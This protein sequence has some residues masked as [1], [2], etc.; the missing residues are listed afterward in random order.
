MPAVSAVLITLDEEARI[1]RALRSVAFCDEVL[2]VDAG[3]SDRTCELAAAAGARVVRNAP[4]PGFAEQRR[5]AT[6]QAR[7]DWVLSVDAD[8]VVTD[9]LG[10][11]IQGLLGGEPP[12]GAY[13]MPRAAFYLGRFIRAT[14]WYP[15]PQL[16]LFDRRRAA[17]QGG[18]VHE[19][20]TAQGPVGRLRGELL[21]YPYADLSEHVRRIDRYTTLWAEDAWERGLRGTAFRLWA[22]PGWNLLRNYVLRGGFLLGRAGLTV[23][24]MNAFYTHL[25]FAKLL[26]RERRP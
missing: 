9:A 21:H 15:D 24:L 14:D 4:F 6:M 7:H 18:R 17:W 20:V 22:T 23:S 13:A 1:E 16:R 3:S 19:S 26:E 2:V 10:A 5:F 25:K 8:E 11:E 12:C